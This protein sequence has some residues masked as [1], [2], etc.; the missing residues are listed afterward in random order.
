MEGDHGFLELEEQE[1]GEKPGEIIQGRPS[2]VPQKSASH[3]IHPEGQLPGSQ[4]L[5]ARWSHGCSLAG[6]CQFAS[7]ETRD[8]AAVHRG[9]SEGSARLPS[10]LLRPLSRGVS[11]APSSAPW[12]VDSSKRGSL[13]RT[14]L[15]SKRS[16][17]PSTK[18]ASLALP[19]LKLPQE[20]YGTTL[21]GEPAPRFSATR[22]QP[23]S[24]CK[25]QLLSPHRA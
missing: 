13:R 17:Q 4:S 15:L 9:E 20:E 23:Q 6:T 21:T 12:S 7:L 2:L 1:R 19:L 5:A 10:V 25:A 22:V 18:P 3:Q 8:S 14:R 11:A 24:D 16:Q